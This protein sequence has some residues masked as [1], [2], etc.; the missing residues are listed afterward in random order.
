MTRALFTSVSLCGLLLTAAAYGGKPERDY[1]KAEAE[2]AVAKAAAAFKT[3]CGGDLKI[4]VNWDSF[5]TL[6]QLR[7]LRHA[8]DDITANV[9]RYCNDAD[10]KKVMSGKLKTIA[11][12][13]DAVTRL[14]YASGKAEIA[15]DGKSYVNWQML[16][17]EVDK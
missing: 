13:V 8:V 10:T 14:T 17:K 11:Y 1:R 2:P 7:V 9:A 4:D 5:T 6:D 16:T 3:S 15:T 12:R